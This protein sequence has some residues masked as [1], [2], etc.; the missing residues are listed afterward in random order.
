MINKCTF[1]CVPAHADKQPSPVRLKISHD[2]W[3]CCVR[4]AALFDTSSKF[5]CGE[6]NQAN[7]NCCIG[8]LRPPLSMNLRDTTCLNQKL[9]FR[10]VLCTALCWSLG[11]ISVIWQTGHKSITN[12]GSIQ[13]ESLPVWCESHM[14]VASYTTW[15]CQQDTR[16]NVWMNKEKKICISHH[17][18]CQTFTTLFCFVFFR[19]CILNH[20]LINPILQ[21]MTL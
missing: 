20:S 8:L 13:Y 18:H 10:L 12:L 5:N 11:N 14:L 2:L 9:K 3:P 21:T 6:K 16:Y 19:E 4:S 1:C 15:R 7:I 17:V